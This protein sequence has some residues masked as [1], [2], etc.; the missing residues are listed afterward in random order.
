MSNPN[1]RVSH[2]RTVLSPVA[3]DQALL[4]PVLEYLHPN[5]YDQVGMSPNPDQ[6]VYYSHHQTQDRN[7]GSRNQ[8]DCPASHPP[9][10][11]PGAFP[12]G[13]LAARKLLDTPIHDEMMST[14]SL[15]GQSPS[16]Q[17]ESRQTLEFYLDLPGT[18]MLDSGSHAV[19]D[20]FNLGDWIHMDNGL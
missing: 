15:P 6:S 7:A 8:L 14:H 4:R 3:S 17:P 20:G 10:V 13:G 16:A 1:H 19:E 11:K 9:L 18:D 2:S 5:L 12:D